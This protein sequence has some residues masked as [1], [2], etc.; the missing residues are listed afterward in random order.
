MKVAYH[1]EEWDFTLSE[2]MFSA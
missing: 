2:H 1:S